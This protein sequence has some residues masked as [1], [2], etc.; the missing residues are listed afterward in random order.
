MK[1]MPFLQVE[2]QPNCH[3]QVRDLLV[4]KHRLGFDG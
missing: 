3:P 1:Q 2:R 4:C